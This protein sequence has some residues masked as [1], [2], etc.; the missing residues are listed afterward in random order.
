MKFGEE[1]YQQLKLD[2]LEENSVSL[3]AK[4]SHTYISDNPE[5]T[6]AR[7][8]VKKA[9]VTSDD[10]E[11][12]QASRYIQYATSRGIELDYILS[13]PIL[14]RPVFLL[15]A[16]QL[17]LK[18]PNKGELSRALLS[19]VDKDRISVGENGGFPIIKSNAIMVD[20]MSVV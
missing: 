15:E 11:N 18:K 2:R 9:L 7:K 17:F 19:S 16:N 20:F 6:R 14:S 1:Q 3:H 8:K 4:I 5:I 10:A 13:H 12:S